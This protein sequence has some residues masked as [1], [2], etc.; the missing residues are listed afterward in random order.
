MALADLPSPLFLLCPWLLHIPT[1]LFLPTC[2]FVLCRLLASTF[3]FCALFSAPQIVSTTHI[4]NSYHVYFCP[5][6]DWSKSRETG[7]LLI[8]SLLILT[9][10]PVLGEST[11]NWSLWGQLLRNQIRWCLQQWKIYPN[12]WEM[13]SFYSSAT[14]RSTWD[15]ESWAREIQ[16]VSKACVHALVEW[17]MQWNSRCIPGS[18]CTYGGRCCELRPTPASS[19]ISRLTPLGI[20]ARMTGCLAAGGQHRHHPEFCGGQWRTSNIIFASFFSFW[21]LILKNLQV[22]A[23]YSR[24]DR[25]ILIYFSTS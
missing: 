25:L 4:D 3:H 12:T 11:D 8:S 15:L 6:L 7:A 17:L 19:S 2:F 5:A 24:T 10:T 13:Q 1:V 14:Q 21:I 9:Y 16:A 18:R 20:T 23:H 22:T